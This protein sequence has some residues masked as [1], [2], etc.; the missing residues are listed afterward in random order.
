[1]VC[2]L[3]QVVLGCSNLIKRNQPPQGV[4]LFTMFP[5]EEPGVAI[6]PERDSDA[7]TW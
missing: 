3:L 6:F 2:F 7:A 1:V 5:N 4:F